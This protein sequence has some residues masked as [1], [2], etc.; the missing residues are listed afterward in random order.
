MRGSTPCASSSSR[1]ARKYDGVTMMI[2]GSKSRISWTWRSVMP[3][4][5]G[6]DGAAQPFGAVVRAETSGEQ[7]V[8]VGDVAQV[9]RAAAG[10]ADRASHHLGPGVD[11]LTGVADDGR[12]AGRTAGGVHP[13][14]LIARHGEHAE[15]IVR[16]QVGLGGEREPREVGQAVQ[17][18]GVTSAW[19][20]A[21][22]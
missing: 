6:H 22:R 13:H 12:L 15:R 9:S 1:I 4:L 5:T 16:A 18:A 21:R 14:D 11:V 8:A 7:P 17:V 19:S 20:K 2:R 10:R 3:P